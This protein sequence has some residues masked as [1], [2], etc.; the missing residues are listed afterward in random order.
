MFI[1]C[2]TYIYTPRDKNKKVHLDKDIY[3]DVNCIEYIAKLRIDNDDYYE[4][5][6]KSSN[7]LLVNKHTFK[8][9]RKC[10]TKGG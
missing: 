6:L 9:I 4:I 8:I 1:S 5:H 2:L 10:L 7:I 3:F